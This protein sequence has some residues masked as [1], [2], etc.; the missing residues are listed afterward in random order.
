MQE[1]ILINGHKGSGRKTVAEHLYQQLNSAAWIHSTWLHCFRLPDTSEKLKEQLFLKQIG[2]FLRN[3]TDLN[4]QRI[5][6]SGGVLDQETF[7]YI[8]ANLPTDTIF[9]YFWLEIPAKERAKRLIDRGRDNAD[10]PLS[11]AKIQEHEVLERPKIKI[12]KNHYFVSN[13]D[14]PIEDIVDELLKCLY[15]A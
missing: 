1:L 5:I 9:K 12:P 3:Y 7:D 6:V 10:S 8:A 13:S 2:H 15:D 14:R 11:V 4:V